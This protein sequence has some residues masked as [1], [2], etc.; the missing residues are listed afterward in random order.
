[1]RGC[2]T[3]FR[4]LIVCCFQLHKACQLRK[5][6]DASA[7]GADFVTLLPEI[8]LTTASRHSDVRPVSL[9]QRHSE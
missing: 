4:G 2:A 3:K 1:M 9:W 7:A 5:S 6:L 8:V